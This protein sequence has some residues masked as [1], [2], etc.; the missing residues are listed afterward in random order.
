[1]TPQNTYMTCLVVNND[2]ANQI[3]SPS[4]DFDS[5]KRLFENYYQMPLIN[6]LPY[7]PYQTLLLFAPGFVQTNPLNGRRVTALSGNH[8][9]IINAL[10]LLIA[11]NPDKD[12]KALCESYY[13]DTTPTER[14]FVQSWIDENT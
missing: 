9:A 11:A 7:S 6:L 2:E 14:F 8:D 1:M 5:I 4:L 10:S 3:A 12:P 13:L